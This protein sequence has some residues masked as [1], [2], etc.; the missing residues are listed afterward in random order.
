MVWLNLASETQ[1][2]YGFLVLDPLKLQDLSNCSAADLN[3]AVV[4]TRVLEKGWLEGYAKPIKTSKLDTVRFEKPSTP[5]A[6]LQTLYFISERAIVTVSAGCLIEALNLQSRTITKSIYRVPNDTKST[7][8]S[9]SFALENTSLYY[10]E[11]QNH[12]SDTDDISQ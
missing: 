9:P 5:E 2:T 6:E 11:Y 12:A 7:V 8:L 10:A 3:E 1:R 4:R